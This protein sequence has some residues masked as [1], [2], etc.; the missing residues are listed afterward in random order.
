MAKKPLR[1]LSATL[2]LLMVASSTVSASAVTVD[3]ANSAATND[4]LSSSGQAI[5][6]KYAT[7]PK[8]QVGKYKTITSASDFT[9]DMIIA[10]GVA[11]DDPRIFRGS[12]EAPVY[13]TYALYSA[14]D[15]SNL[16]LGWQFTN[17]TDI[18]DP[19]QGYPTSDNGKPWNGDI[20]QMLALDLG[21]GKSADMSSGTMAGGEYVWGLKVGFETRIDA[22]MCFSSK[23]GVGQPAL[24][25]TGSDGLFSY[26]NP[27]PALFKEN[28]I[29]F[30]YEDGFF[31]SSITG[32][33]KNG[34]EGYVP[35]DLTSASSNWVDFL[36]LGHDKKHDTFY[37]MTVPFKALGIT[38]DH[39]E[40]NGIGVMHIST[41]GEGGIASCPMDMTMLDKATTAYSADESTSAEKEDT[42]LVTVPLARIGNGDIP[43]NPIDPTDPPV[44]PDDPT[45]PP[46]IPTSPI[47][48]ADVTGSKE[49]TV[50]A[51]DKV[52][53][54][55]DV[56]TAKKIGGYLMTTKYDADAFE[57][58][59]TYSTD[60]VS[61]LGAS[62]GQEIVN[63]TV[64][65]QVK[66]A[67]LAPASKPYTAA[68]GATLQTIQLK[69]KK[70]GT[71]TIS[72]T[73]DEMNDDSEN[74]L[75]SSNKPVSGVTVAEKAAVNGE[76]PVDPETAETGSTTA[77]FKAGNTVEYYVDMKFTKGLY[78]F[79]TDVKYDSS[80]LEFVKA[81]Y[82]NF[83]GLT[84]ENADVA[85]KF[86]VIGAG[87]P[88]KPY[89]FTTEKTLVK[90]TFKA[91]A[92]A[93]DSK[94][95]YTMKQ[96][97]DPDGKEYF[98]KTTGQPLTADV[99]TTNK[100]KV[101]G[102]NPVEGATTASTEVTVKAGDKVNYWVEV[103]I[104]AD[105]KYDV[106]GW[107]TELFFDPDVFNA[108]MDFADG[109][110]FASGTA[111]V[112]YVLGKSSTAVDL[113]GGSMVQ[114]TI[115]DGKASAIDI[116]VGGMKFKGKTTKL[117]CIQLIAEKD[118][119]TTLSYR[120]K[121]MAESE[122][123]DNKIVYVDTTTYQPIDGAAFEIKT[124]IIRKD[125]PI[126]PPVP[127]GKMIYLMPNA[128]WIKGDA[129]FAV[130][131][132]GPSGTQWISMTDLEDGYFGADIPADA[133]SVK[134]ARMN[135]KSEANTATNIWNYTSVMTIPTDGTNCY[136][137]YAGEWNDAK[138]EWSVYISKASLKK[139]YLKPNANWIKT[140]A[141]F[142]MQ[143]FAPNGASE[144]VSMEDAGDGY[145]TAY[146]PTTEYTQ[147]KFAR[148]SGSS[149]ANTAANIWNYSSVMTFP[150]KADEKNCFFIKDAEWNDVAGD[151]GVF[152]P[153]VYEPD[154]LY[155]KP[156]LNWTYNKYNKEARFSAYLYGGESPATWV[157][158]T[159][160][161]DGNYKLVIP[162]GDY[163]KLQ[164][165]R[166]DV[167]TT[168]NNWESLW[169][170]SAEMEI[171]TNG[172]NRFV[173]NDDAWSS[174]EG[175][176]DS[177]TELK[178]LYLKPNANWLGKHAN[179]RFSAYLYGGE[180]PATWVSMTK[181]ADG[182]YKADMPAGH[183]T[184][185]IFVR[186]NPDTTE[187]VWANNWNES[188]PQ[189]IPAHT[190]N[191]FTLN[192]AD[193]NSAEG[194]W[195]AK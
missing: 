119:T 2:A 44:V 42:D 179:P 4:K 144:W 38:K 91:L 148:M 137:I 67:V 109:Y 125:N 80:A 133:T 7:N 65:G 3:T 10:Q 135:P 159:K 152:T 186:M 105:G 99:A 87:S 13:D 185:V 54:T 83:D 9:E 187:N 106:S 126:D 195:T 29:S 146:V 166:M 14:W 114:A 50:A 88:T 174:A 34:Y 92:D 118:A 163:K 77:S 138:G 90:V 112:D 115:T 79:Q 104:P 180:S 47:G 66:S 153:T 116:K 25:K 139:L 194:V 123:A 95:S 169:N 121:D 49:V 78:G 68:D 145:Y 11:N 81:E 56:T 1:L 16:Y 57:L 35:E 181:Q 63:T 193:W 94:I 40:K 61:T 156:N 55:V 24:F 75:V 84:E 189:R 164:F 191:F 37:Y 64:A 143:V 111:A 141:R 31:G 93:T 128:N 188:T 21:T 18:V 161:A 136:T 60:G 162:A 12:H 120:Q 36:S 160:A 129:R 140:D 59:T 19:A 82:P 15:D 172:T 173:L 71:Y 117:F 41:F 48:P 171:P 96:T 178:T 86:S 154:A 182:S 155:L 72:Y 5:G 53:F 62:D 165:A 46:I 74:D 127:T 98:N 192:A 52:T 58:D 8:G 39:I 43:V 149:T 167:N 100:A 6:G 142:A 85:G 175:I 97:M 151:W 184:K 23:P 45:D 51:G 32:I 30:K 130:Q 132:S 26:T 113:P 110:G 33:K 177:I 190:T 22:L 103:S 107:T 101:V 157:S 122:T 102:A 73:I 17:V 168:A 70:A 176:W 131:V 183:Y 150:V 27:A 108:N 76:T 124:D 134:F 28:G 158:L 147:V 69:A 20:P 170:D 89:D